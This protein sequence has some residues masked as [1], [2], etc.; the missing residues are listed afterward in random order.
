[1]PGYGGYAVKK[2]TPREKHQ[3]LMAI[4]TAQILAP[5]VVQRVTAYRPVNLYRAQDAHIDTA[6]A[7]AIPLHHGLY[8]TDRLLSNRT[9]KFPEDTLIHE[10]AHLI[11]TAQINE[12]D[13]FW[14]NF[15]LPRMLRVR[16]SAR[17]RGSNYFD[18]SFR[19][20]TPVFAMRQDRQFRKLAL[21]EGMPAL[22]ACTNLA[23]ALATCVERRVKGYKPPA[24]MEMFLR[25]RY[26]KTPY[27]ADV[28]S[29][30]VHH[31]MTLHVERKQE[32]AIEAYTHV[33][34]SDPRFRTLLRF[35]ASLYQD[36]REYEQAI[37]DLSRSL[38]IFRATPKS[39][40]DI[41]KQRARCFMLQ[42][43]YVS[44]IK[45]ITRAIKISEQSK[46]QNYVSR[47]DVWKRMG[48]QEKALKDLSRAIRLNPYSIEAYRQRA[49]LW[50]QQGDQTK[51]EADWTTLIKLDPHGVYALR[52]R[53]NLYK[54]QAQYEKAIA[55][56][57]SIVAKSPQDR[58]AHIARAQSK[59]L[60]K[61]FMGAAE[62][63]GQL[64]EIFPAMKYRYCIDRGKCYL[65][66]R[67]FQ[68]ALQDF[69]AALQSRENYYPAYVEKSWLLATC[70]ELNLRDGTE[71]KVLAIKACEIVQHRQWRCLETLA[72]AC[73]ENGE[74]EEAIDWQ[75]KA[76]EMTPNDEHRNAAE[77]RLTLYQKN[78]PFRQIE[79]VDE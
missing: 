62:D 25:E 41:Y 39:K 73:A 49:Y 64:I 12:T 21:H 70:P 46:S 65:Q 4:E 11:D 8:V 75:T 57:T 63:Y 26:F 51:E 43:D 67:Q 50:R 44:A 13:P 31:A 19:Q 48:E 2:W 3:I 52:N 14:A 38:E 7:I 77:E 71:A 78:Q 29:R 28:T 22:Y 60:N 74:F 17:Q 15:V 40:G 9:K 18:V 5:G 76:L 58:S 33:I 23:E 34:E 68:L 36:R 59:K 66:N 42:R 20:L 72:A 35:R 69:D 61:D 30:Q 27:R 45:D 32:E 37:E 16:A 53:A 47:A 10:W 55:D 1:M 6:L 24:E 79:R 56:Y 54:K